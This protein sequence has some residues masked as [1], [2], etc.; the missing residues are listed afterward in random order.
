MTDEERA[1]IH[2]TIDMFEVIVD[3]QP[4]DTQ[5]MEILKE[6]YLKLSRN[7]EAVDM[8]SRIA[9]AHVELGQLSSAI[10]EYEGILELFPDN[11]GAKAALDSIESKASASS[12]SSITDEPITSATEIA[13]TQDSKNNSTGDQNVD[14]GRNVMEK[15]F[16][17]S[18]TLSS[19]NFQIY[20]PAADLGSQP[21]DVIEPFLYV[22]SEQGVLSIEDSLKVLCDK[23]PLAYLPMEKYDIDI[24]LARTFPPD[25]CRRWCILPFDRLSTSV[26]VAT[27][28]PFNRQAAAQIAEAAKS[29]IIWYLAS[30]EYLLTQLRQI[31]R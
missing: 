8:A 2:Q 9:K 25:I 3:S 20:W 15:I 14:D 12:T 13:R 1:Q 29:R 21:S 5:S 18:G 11:E 30:P 19:E 27:A 4:L 22:L 28:N 17:E 10:L 16:T 24:E 26:L 23:S 31:L 7:D 6:A